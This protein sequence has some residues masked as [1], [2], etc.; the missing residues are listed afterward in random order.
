MKQEYDD[1]I[2]IGV[3]MREEDWGDLGVKQMTPPVPNNSEPVVNQVMHDLHR[4][5]VMGIKKYG[6]PL[7]ANNGRDA[8]QDALEEVYDLACYLKQFRLEMDHDKELLERCL[9]NLTD[10]ELKEDL[11][12]TLKTRYA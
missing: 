9:G 7:Q 2:D 11:S 4:R 10:P 8:L 3:D 1:M 5:K 6:T 12:S